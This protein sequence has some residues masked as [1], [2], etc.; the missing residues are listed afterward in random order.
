MM[1]WKSCLRIRKR[2]FMRVIKLEFRAVMTLTLKPSIIFAPGFNICTKQ[3]VKTCK[4]VV[5]FPCNNQLQLCSRPRP[6]WHLHKRNSKIFIPILTQI[7]VHFKTFSDSPGVG[8]LW[9]IQPS[10]Q[11]N[12]NKAPYQGVNVRVQIN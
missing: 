4:N 7:W 12:A 6:I 1:S 11:V 5:Q 8:M 9:R 10:I 3:T 2:R